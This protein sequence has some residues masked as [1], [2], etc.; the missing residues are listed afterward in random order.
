MAVINCPECNGQISD[1]CKNCIHCGA[2]IIICPECK[3]VAVETTKAC[4]KCGY[5]FKKLEEGKTKSTDEEEKPRKITAMQFFEEC[6]NKGKISVNRKIRK[7]FHILWTVSFV[8]T[9]LFVILWVMDMAKSSANALAFQSFVFIGMLFCPI[10]YVAM[11]VFDWVFTRN[12][13]IYR[14]KIA[15]STGRSLKTIIDNTLII[16]YSTKSP[17]YIMKQAEGL[18]G[19]LESELSNIDY[20]FRRVINVQ[21]IIKII[22]TYI[23]SIFVYSALSKVFMILDSGLILSGWQLVKDE[24]VLLVLLILPSIIEIIY[25][26]ILSSYSNK[27]RREWIVKNYPNHIE[28]Y[29]KYLSGKKVK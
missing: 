1:T 10:F 29:D 22:L 12:S 3:S 14:D 15:K 17:E 11:R 7:V 26:I 16:K 9:V 27:K 19:V 20:S 8:F 13:I 24:W 23:E 25:D 4:S 21:L 6:K 2:S 5:S 28:V 18:Q